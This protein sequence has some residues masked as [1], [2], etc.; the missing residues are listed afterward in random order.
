[1]TTGVNGIEI[2]FELHGDGEP[3]LPNI[4]SSTL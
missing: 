4:L 1:M 2:Y 3:I